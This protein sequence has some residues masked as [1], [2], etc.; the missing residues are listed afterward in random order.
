MVT[1]LPKAEVTTRR[2]NKSVASFLIGFYYLLFDWL[3]AVLEMYF[4]KS[5]T[6][7]DLLLKLVIK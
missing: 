4:G 1:D 7:V 5:S 2:L 6:N 3:L